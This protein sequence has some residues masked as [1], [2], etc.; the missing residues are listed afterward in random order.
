MWSNIMDPKAIERAFQQALAEHTGV[1]APGEAHG[2]LDVGGTVENIETTFCKAWPKV[3][4]YLKLLISMSGWVPGMSQYS[5][6]ALAVIKAIGTTV[7]P[8]ICQTK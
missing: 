7:V 1:T 3:E 2:L 5:A 8:G 4:K 6:M